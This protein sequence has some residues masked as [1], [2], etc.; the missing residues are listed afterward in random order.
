[1]YNQQGNTCDHVQSTGEYL[2]WS[3]IN[4]EIPVI[5]YNQQ[6]NTCAKVQS[7]GEYLWSRTINRGIPVT[8]YNHTQHLIPMGCQR[9]IWTTGTPV[10]TYSQQGNTCDHVQSTGEHKW[11]C[12]VK[13]A[14]NRHGNTCD[15]MQSTEEQMWPRTVN[16][17]T[18]NGGTP[19]TTYKQHGNTH[20]WSHTIKGGTTVTTYKRKHLWPRTINSGTPVTTYNQ[21][22]K[23]RPGRPYHTQ[24]QIDSN[25]WSTYKK[26]NLVQQNILFGDT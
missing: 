23:E 6:G 7:T 2:C 13:G 24:H 1:M 9:G 21:Q 15:Y 20:L 4:R 5:T 17:G 26:V 10:A 19:V 25:R 11:P 22:R 18:L 14:Y 12:T 16:R 3:T 8:M